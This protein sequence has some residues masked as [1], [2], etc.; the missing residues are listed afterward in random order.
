MSLGVVQLAA[1]H[2]IHR[3]EP[4]RSGFEGTKLRDIAPGCGFLFEGHR[5]VEDCCAGVEILS[6]RLPKSGPTGLAAL[7]EAASSGS[8]TTVSVIAVSLG[9]KKFDR[10]Q[11]CGQDIRASHAARGEKGR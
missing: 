3:Q 2:R 10:L 4:A 1:G 9:L 5:A 8:V 7:L 11:D 6:R